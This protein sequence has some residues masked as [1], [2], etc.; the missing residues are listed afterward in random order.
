M[1]TAASPL[2]FGDDLALLRWALP[3]LGVLMAGAGAAGWSSGQLTTFAAWVVTALGLAAAVWSVRVTTRR[4]VFDASAHLVHIYTRSGGARRTHE[5]IPFADVS[6]V[7]LQ[8]VGRSERSG[9]SPLGGDLQFLLILVAGGRDIP[10]S[11]L[12]EHSLPDCVA[13]DARVWRVI[14]RTPPGDLLERS[15]RHFLARSDRLQSI[16]LA[17]LLTPGASLAEAEARVRREALAR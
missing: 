10:L 3:P 14:E 13:S 5:A 11:R 6:D 15:Y 16:W 4:I 17:R 1:T 8:V 12:P 9:E 7:V 2:E